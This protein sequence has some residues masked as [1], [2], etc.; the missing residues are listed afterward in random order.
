M[1]IVCGGGGGSGGGGGG[2]SGGGGTFP[3]PILFYKIFTFRVILKK[4]NFV[5]NPRGIPCII[6]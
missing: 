2:G 5:K 3:A 1:L 4:F 6:S